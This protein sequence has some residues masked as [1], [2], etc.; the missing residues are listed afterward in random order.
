MPLRFINV[1]LEIESNNSL[2]YLCLDLSSSGVHHLYSGPSGRGY[3]ARLECADGGDTCEPDSIIMKF[4]DA[5]DHLDER[6]SEEWKN[7]KFRCF[8]L[9]YEAIDSDQTWQSALRH[10]T[11]SRVV[12]LGASIYFT[13]YP[14][15]QSEQAAPCNP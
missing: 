8:D 9:G 10:A 4:C 3:L 7:A 12:A 14:K 13:A 1:D 11:L 2:D 15:N 5:I 6:A